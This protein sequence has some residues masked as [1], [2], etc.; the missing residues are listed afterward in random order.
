MGLMTCNRTGCKNIMCDRYSPAY[1]YICDACFK[2]LV[3][4]ELFRDIGT[5]MGEHVSS[6]AAKRGWGTLLDMLF[7]EES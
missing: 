7:K 1:G 6:D 5:F 4:G 3:V 2:E